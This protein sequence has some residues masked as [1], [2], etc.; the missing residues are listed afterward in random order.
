MNG[1]AINKDAVRGRA[2]L[3]ASLDKRLVQDYSVLLHQGKITPDEYTAIS[4]APL[5]NEYASVAAT[6]QNVSGTSSTPTDNALQQ[7]ALD[8]TLRQ[9]A[10][11]HQRRR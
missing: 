8:A 10:S 11:K 7:L 9:Y 6:A 5:R 2:D 1:E 4:G 3:N